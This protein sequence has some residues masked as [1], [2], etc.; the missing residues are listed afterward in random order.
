MAQ[1]GPTSQFVVNVLQ[2]NPSDL[3]Q[4]EDE[5][6]KGEGPGV[7][8]REGFVI[9]RQFR[10]RQ[11]SQAHSPHWAY[12]SVRMKAE[13]RGKVGMSWGFWKAQ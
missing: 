4:G 9:Q 2:D 11:D 8:T 10:H 13:L 7:V 6:S 3:H 5:G 1:P 12:R